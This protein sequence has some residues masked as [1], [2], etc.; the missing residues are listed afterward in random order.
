[1]ISINLAGAVKQT[2]EEACNMGAID[3]VEECIKCGERISQEFP[4]EI[5]K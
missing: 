4:R 3:L 1:M 5:L 2:I